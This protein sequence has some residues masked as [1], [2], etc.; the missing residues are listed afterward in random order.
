MK[1]E[2][3]ESISGSESEVSSGGE[4][5]PLSTLLRRKA[6][7]SAAEQEEEHV[8]GGQT[9]QGPGNAPIVWFTS[10]LLPTEVS[11]GAYRALFSTAE[12]KQSHYLA[13][14]HQKQLSNP[15]NKDRHIFLCMIGGGHFAAMIVSLTP[16]NH[17]LQSTKSDLP[18]HILA[19]KTFH[20]Y[21][22]RRKQGGAQSSNDAAKGAAHS[23]GASI[24]RYNEAALVT[25]VRELLNEWKTYLDTADLLFIRAT[26]SANR[27]TLFNDTPLAKNDTRIRSF[28]FSTRRAT[29]S[30]LLRCFAE[31][32][33]LKTS[34]LTAEALLP[35]PAPAPKPPKPAASPP[36][37]QYSPEEESALTHTYQL[38]AVIK[39]AKTQ[40]LLSYLTNNTLTPNYPFF[41]ATKNHQSPTPLHMAAHLNH[42]DVITALLVKMKADPTV[43]NADGHTP[44]E[45]A[46]TRAARDAFRVAR[47]ELGEAAWDWDGAGVPSALSK[48]EA[49]AR[50]KREREEAEKEEKER[51]ERELA[52][53]SQEE[54]EKRA[55]SRNVGGKGKGGRTLGGLVA[56]VVLQSVGRESETRGLSEEA[57]VRLERE[58]RARAAEERIKRLQGK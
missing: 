44:F 16:K 27:A 14:L 39:R 43:K 34:R 3:N 26:G 21:T 1:A 15:T 24:R 9:R 4:D 32:T 53:L 20:R 17:K 10:P 42:R 30:E 54:R 2:L 52:T 33:R 13:S 11:L 49:A 56:P 46:G 35:K 48:P 7:I 45:L 25:E 19:H 8:V 28:P 57:K 41:P 23:A 50:E 37:P 36:P 6:M 22:T 55:E 58:R 18:V 5:G 31:L 38:Q 29:Q 47:H 51:R 40:A 12:Q